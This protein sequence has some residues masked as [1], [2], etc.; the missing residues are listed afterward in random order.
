[1]STYQE[2]IS[3]LSE[4]QYKPVYLLHGNEPFFI[5][6]ITDFITNNVLTEAE[7]G[8]NQTIF[9]GRDTEIGSIIETAKRYPMMAEKQV[10]IIREAQ[11]LKQLEK[12]DGYLANPV[13][14][15]ILVFAY[16]YK[17]PDGRKKFAKLIKK[18][19][20]VFESKTIYDN[21]MSK[22]VE[23]Y[24]HQH[25]RKITPKATL[26]ISEYIGSN[27]SLA[28]NEIEKLFIS[29]PEGG[30]IDDNAVSEV[31]G[32]NKDFNIFEFQNAFGT[33]DFKKAM[34]IAIHFGNHQK[35]HPYVMV[36]S[37]LGKYFTNLVLMYFSPKASRNDLARM[38]GVNPYFMDDFYTA[39]SNFGAG[40]AVKAIELIREYD[41]KAKGVNSSGIPS[42]ELL[43][44]LVFKIFN[45]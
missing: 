26:L 14:S 39:K 43:K 29:I 42:G 30:H 5:D 2:I 32:I 12:L 41:V 25:Q 3:Q 37:Q 21:Q 38:I 6:K 17:K 35:E 11:D 45:N 34:Q 13:E 7:K 8:F 23:S 27:L 15:T 31:I 9:Y 24:V 1:M 16:K 36:I 33:R 19:G 4:R 44:E 18:H 20:V 22:W 40:S 10:V 28:S